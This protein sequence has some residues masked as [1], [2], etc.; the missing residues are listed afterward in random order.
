MRIEPVITELDGNNA[1]QASWT[2]LQQLGSIYKFLPVRG[3]ER[4][5]V[6]TFHPPPPPPPSHRNVQL[7]SLKTTSVNENRAC[8]HGL[9]KATMLTAVL[10][11]SESP[12]TVL[13]FLLLMA[14]FL[15]S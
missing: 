7:H 9:R 14:P 6:S 5:T 13:N 4:S 2:T 8:N 15:T 3:M 10:P 12:A 11:K 1:N